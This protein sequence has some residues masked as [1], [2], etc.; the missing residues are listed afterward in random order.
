LEKKRSDLQTAKQEVEDKARDLE[1]ASEYKSMF[2]ANMSHEIRTPMNGV[3]GMISLLLDT[4]LND[5]QFS[6][7]NRINT[8]ADALLRVI[9]DILDYSKIEAGKL[10]LE[11][12]DFNMRTTVEDVA[13]VLATT[14]FDKGLEL[15]SLI[16][17]DLPTLVQGD[18]VRLRQILM[19]LAGNAIKFTQ[20]GEVVI[21]AF[22]EKED[23]STVTIRFKVSDTGIGI[24]KDRMDC[25]F[26]S[27]SQVDG[28]T[29]RQ[30]GGTGLGLAISKQL[31]RMMNG[32]IGVESIEGKGTT[33]WFT[34][35]FKKQPRGQEPSFA[36]PQE[37]GSKRILVVDD[38]ETN[39]IL[40]NQQLKAWQC[41]TDDASNGDDALEKL[42]IALDNNDPF[43]I[44]ILDM[45]MPGMNGEILGRKIK[46]DILLS[47]TILIMLTSMGLKGD[48]KRARDI[49]F[50]A[51]LS[52]PIKQSQLF[53]CLATVLGREISSKN[54]AHCSI[55]TKY[56]IADNIKNKIRILL[57]EDDETNQLVASSMLKKMGFSV[58]I[59]E[60]GKQAV[61]SL[62]KGAFDIVLMDGQMP[63]MDGF[64][65]TREIRKQEKQEN[66]SPIHIIALTAHAMKGDRE[67]FI[68]AGM[69]DYITKP[70]NKD[71]LLEK[72]NN[73]IKSRSLN[74]PSE[75]VDSKESQS[76][77]PKGAKTLSKDPPKDPIDR[78]D[79]L[80][81]MDN[82]M[83][84]LKKCF[85]E[86][87][88][89]S[90]Q[91]LENIKIAIDAQNGSTL[92]KVAHNFKGMLSYL[93]AKKGSDIAGQ[94]ELI[95][96]EN[97]ID[98]ASAGELYEELN[99]ECERINKYIIG[100]KGSTT[101]ELKTQGLLT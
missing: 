12:I 73:Y 46:K 53:D 84:L 56:S 8:S 76:D 66:R 33:F 21:R 27:F 36:L 9:N 17:H 41:R 5:E 85:D 69:N 19:N 92:E 101:P 80:D 40:L 49:G 23:Q 26:Q 71:I 35:V 99:K 70:V 38:N 88:K 44:A 89:S 47:N 20:A 54:T 83:D 43:H 48:A 72:L 28:S 2:L 68:T 14:A 42:R 30:Y 60:N 64:E 78:E 74:T 7:A 63:I 75:E 77:D 55:V 79:L 50:S 3:I 29:T 34:S 32:K 90:S 51:Y 25:L 91:L 15:I 86:F 65:A 24:P 52:K 37:I 1:Q 22:L 13:D 97:R 93:S 62:E 58:I 45:Q 6:Y 11:T 81:I 96:K 39:R 67:K 4:K 10:T 31:C 95:G 18:P 59:A 82:D 16:R 98:S 57:A 100:F 87:M 94:L 61:E